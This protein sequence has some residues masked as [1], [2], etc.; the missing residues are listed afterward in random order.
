VEAKLKL[1][2]SPKQNISVIR[3][4]VASRKAD[5]EMIKAS[6]RIEGKTVQLAMARYMLAEAQYLLAEI[7]ANT[8]PSKPVR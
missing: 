6:R 3:R 1:T 5:L 8:P 7:E 2:D 4:Y